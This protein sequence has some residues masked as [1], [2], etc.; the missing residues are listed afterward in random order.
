MSGLAS[1]KATFNLDFDSM[2][3]FKQLTVGKAVQIY[4]REIIYIGIK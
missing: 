4:E 1:A 2:P 3:S